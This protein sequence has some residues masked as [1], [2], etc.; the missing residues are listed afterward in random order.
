MN[1]FGKLFLFSTLCVFAAHCSTAHKMVAGSGRQLIWSDEFNVPG[2]PDSTKWGYDYGTGCPNNC[3][4]GNNELEFYTARR[5]EN[6]RVENGLLIV[7]ARREKWEKSAY[8]SARLVSKN[9]G[10]WTYGRIEARLKCPAGRGTW[11]AFWMLSTDWKYGGWPRSGEIDIMEHVGFMPDSIFGS[12]HTE[13]FNHVKHTQS[14]R[15]YYLP[16]AEKQ[17]HVYAV[18]WRPDRIDYYIDERKYHT[19]TNQHK[20]PD[21]WPFDQRFHILLNLA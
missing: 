5:A 14:T 18:E 2:L 13:A 19:F 16:D 10:D 20:T 12:A 1:A 3:G 6:A 8:T 4:W 7:E 21:E 11:P 9:K 15:G 17:F